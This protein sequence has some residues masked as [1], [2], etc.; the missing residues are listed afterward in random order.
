[1]ET[2]ALSANDVLAQM[3]ALKQ[4]AAQKSVTLNPVA[5]ASIVTKPNSSQFGNVFTQALDKVNSLQQESASLSKRVAMGDDTVSL[6]ETMI[7]SQKSA[8][9]FQATLQVRNKLVEAYKEI[10]SMPV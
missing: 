8:V 10:K 5:D 1:M 2:K 4:A 3:R 7:A 9:A 6:A